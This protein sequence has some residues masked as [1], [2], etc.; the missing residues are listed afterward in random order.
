MMTQPSS[1]RNSPLLRKVLA[2]GAGTLLSFILTACSDQQELATNLD[3]HQSIDLVV[4]LKGV[5]ISSAR[6]RSSAGNDSRY[7][8]AVASADYLRALQVMHEYR[9]PADRTERFDVVTAPQGLVPNTPEMNHLRLDHALALEVERVVGSLPGVLDA[10]AVVRTSLNPDGAPPSVALVVRY[11]SSSGTIPFATEEIKKLVMKTV[12]GTDGDA[13]MINASRVFLPV[14]APAEGGDDPSH[15]GNAAYIQLRPF[16]FRVVASERLKAYAQIGTLLLGATF[17]G[18]ILGAAVVYST[19]R[20]PR[21][22]RT[23][24]TGGRGLVPEVVSRS[25]APAPA[26]GTEAGRR[27]NTEI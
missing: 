17:S 13:I 23:A 8:V 4:A 14:V 12:P 2:I 27:R 16:P 21:R 19:K 18:I 25:A 11:L 3:S 20:Q 15:P 24:S 10:K 26:E 22:R 6:E 7:T 9:L 1:I 5:G